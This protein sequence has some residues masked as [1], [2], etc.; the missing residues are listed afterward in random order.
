[1]TKEVTGKHLFIT[2]PRGGFACAV[3]APSALAASVEAEVG[4]G[5]TVQV[6]KTIRIVT[7]RKITSTQ[8]V[9]TGSQISELLV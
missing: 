3:G 4:N 2:Y 5:A 9:T 6:V 8:E 1:M 7:G